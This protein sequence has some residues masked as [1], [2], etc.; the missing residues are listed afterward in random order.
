LRQK[1]TEAT[2]PLLG[3]AELRKRTQKNVLSE[4]VGAK[5]GGAGRWVVR[6]ERGLRP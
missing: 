4:G 5:Q 1:K 2:M 6:G 3:G